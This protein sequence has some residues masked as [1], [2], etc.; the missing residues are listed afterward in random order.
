MYCDLKFNLKLSDLTTP[1][2]LYH[3]FYGTYFTKYDALEKNSITTTKNYE[4]L[5][6]NI[7][8]KYTEETISAK[9]T[10][11]YLVSET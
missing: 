4:R 2:D 5:I 1:Y 11:P 8:R 7:L 3:K 10:W 6:K 9:L